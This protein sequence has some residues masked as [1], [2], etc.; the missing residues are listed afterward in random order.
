MVKLWGF[1]CIETQQ[2]YLNSIFKTFFLPE[3]FGLLITNSSYLLMTIFYQ[4]RNIS[5]RFIS[6]SE[7]FASELLINLEE[8]FPWDYMHSTLTTSACST[9]YKRVNELNTENTSWDRLRNNTFQN[10]KVQCQV[11]TWHWT[12]HRNKMMLL[13][14]V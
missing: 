9:S 12:F 5:W 8:M 2:I 4:Y 10:G 13:Y 6:N 1:W 7:A 3:P 11:T 14:T